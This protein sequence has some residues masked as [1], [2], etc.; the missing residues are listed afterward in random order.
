MPDIFVYSSWRL[1][2]EKDK[3]WRQSTIHFE[4]KISL[5]FLL[6]K[7]LFSQRFTGFSIHFRS[8]LKSQ[9]FLTILFK[10]TSFTLC[11]R[12]TAGCLLPYPLKATTLIFSWTHSQ[13]FL[14]A[15]CDYM[16]LRPVQWNVSEMCQTSL[17]STSIFSL[18]SKLQPCRW[19]KY[20]VI[21]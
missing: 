7:K 18:Q 8:L 1:H 20:S 12:P 2:R 6:F 15:R 13:T 10:T 4:Y 17:H 3:N 9:V 11:W 16:L 21:T 14:E 19:R 5:L